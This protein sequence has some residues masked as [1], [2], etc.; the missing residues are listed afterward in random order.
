MPRP[1]WCAI[2]SSRS[3][4][5]A[6]RDSR[7]RLVVGVRYL[8]ERIRLVDQTKYLLRNRRFPPTGTTS[9]PTCRSRRRRCCTPAPVQPIGPQ[10][11]APLFPMALIEQEVSQERYIEIPDEVRDI[12]TPVAA[13]AAVPRAAAGAGAGYAGAHLLQVR[14]RQP[15]RS[16]QAE[17]GRRAGL[18][19]QAGGHQAAR[20]RDRRRPVGQRAGVGLRAV[21]PRSARSTWCASATSRSRIAAR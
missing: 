18:L 4:R 19:Q 6:A 12:Y 20:H 7:V 11:L 9:S 17:H 14:G 13:L 21:R 2:L 1:A 10:D 15:G 5:P 16:P 8:P 3:A